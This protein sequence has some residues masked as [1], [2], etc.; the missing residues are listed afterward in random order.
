M[1]IRLG[2]IA[3]G[4][5][6]GL[7]YQTRA[8][9]DHLHPVKTLLI[10]LSERK[11]LPLH[12][13]WFPGAT[14]VKAP[15]ERDLARFL[16]GLDVVLCC[17]TPINYDLFRLA[18]LRGVRTVLQI[19]FEFLDYFRDPFLPKP[20]VFAT[21]SPWNLDRLNPGPFPRVWPLPVPIDPASIP[22]RQVTEARTFLHVGGRPAAR[23]RNGTHDFIHLAAR[24]PNLDARWILACQ[25]PGPELRR[26]IRGTRVELLGDVPDPGD[27]YAV[28][29]IMILPRRYGGL[30]M[31]AL[32]ALT[33]GMPV[34][35]PDIPPNNLWLPADWLAPAQVID[36]LQAKTSI[37]LH[38][39]DPAALE[40]LIR[41]AHAD[42]GMV[43]DWAATARSIAKRWTWDELLPSYRDFLD[44]VMQLNP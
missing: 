26:A 4:T 35:M 33:A 8:L 16:D 38:H 3:Y 20:T 2:L 24:C 34:I 13:E 40:A 23:D 1:S 44:R 43:A 22:Q 21:P 39:T 36:T 31:P 5:P 32:E 37:D 12:R 29:D 41:R 19:N 28:G 17:E 25:S 30:C 18:R 11:G 9:H 15:T 42:P 27:L 14:V 6:T 10:D 7:G